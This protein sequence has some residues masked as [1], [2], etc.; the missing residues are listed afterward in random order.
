MTQVIEFISLNAAWFYLACGLAAAAF[1]TGYFIARRSAKQSLFG[2]EF[3]VATQRQRN[4]LR[5][6]FILVG[7]G[8][9]V[10]LIA[11]VIEPNLVTQERIDPTPTPDIFATPPPTF[12]N[13]TPTATVAITATVEIITTETP[14]PVLATL[15][16]ATEEIT[17]T[18]TLPSTQPFNTICA[19]TDPIEGSEVS[20]SVTFIGS[21][22]TDQFLFYKL[23]AYGP[24]TDGIWASLLDDVVRTPV[25]DGVLGSANLGGW[26]SGGYSIRLVIVDTT[27]NEIAGCYLS[28]SVA[29]Q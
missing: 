10:F 1:L 5:L 23:E 7:I 8:V 22:T 26:A 12:T 16:P 2:L 11:N 21:A 20:G 4:A 6:F 13:E 3:E 27:S 15:P 9:I 17:I 28:I 29:G 14:Q 25:V 18:P 24:E 19:I